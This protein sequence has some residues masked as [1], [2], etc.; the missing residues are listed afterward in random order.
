[1]KAIVPS[2]TRAGLCSHR[3]SRCGGL[4]AWLKASPASRINGVFA[5]HR[6]QCRHRRCPQ[7]PVCVAQGRTASSLIMIG[8]G[9]ATKAKLQVSSPVAA[10]KSVILK[11]PALAQYILDTS[12]YPK[13]HEQLKQLRETT[14][15]KYGFKSVMN[16]AEDEAQF[17]SILLK[18]MKAEKTLEIGV[19]TGYS[20]LSTA[21]ALPPH[22]KIIAIDVDRE[23]YET[24]LPFIL[25]AGVEDK[26]DFIQA[27]DA[28]SALKDL[29]EVSVVLA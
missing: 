19:F 18:I 22:G 21:L 5:N 3:I 7:L 16:V 6:I 27:A 26:I 12:A 15:Q 9:P 14:V 28:L 25:K 23:A 29:V 2:S 1:M 10:P 20:L 17:L 4:S 13:E 8:T 11:S 24:G